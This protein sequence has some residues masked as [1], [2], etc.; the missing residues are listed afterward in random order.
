MKKILFLLILC[1][2]AC[3][4]WS[5][6]LADSKK[7]TAEKPKFVV[8]TKQTTADAQQTEKT[9]DSEDESEQTEAEEMPPT[10]IT[11]EQKAEINLQTSRQN[12]GNIRVQK[13]KDRR[14]FL[15]ALQMLD[16]TAARQ[17]AIAEGKSEKEIEESAEKV[18]TPDVNPLDDRDLEKY[19]FKKVDVNERI[20]TTDEQ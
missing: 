18:K 13:P 12:R 3:P 17:K 2:V 5:Q 20:K 11:P 6:H 1:F 7:V 15:D 4:A 9:T 8:Q 14:I 16:K 19:L 10:T